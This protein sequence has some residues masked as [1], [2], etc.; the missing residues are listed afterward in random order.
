MGGKEFTDLWYQTKEKETERNGGKQSVQ[1]VW[2]LI[3]AR[4]ITWL[5]HGNLSFSFFLSLENE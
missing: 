4:T 2:S 1:N 5:T 3:N